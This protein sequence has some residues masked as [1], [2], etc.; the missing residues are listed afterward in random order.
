MHLA[1]LWDDTGAGKPMGGDQKFSHA[2]EAVALGFY[3]QLLFPILTLLTQKRDNAVVGIEQLDDVQ[4]TVGG[5]LLLQQLKHS[6]SSAPKPVTLKSRA[7]WQTV[8]VW[9]DALPH[10]T[11]SEATLHL[12][13]VGGIPDGDP[14]KA[15]YSMDAARDEL[16]NSLLKEA[17]RVVDA[18][19]AAAKA[20]KAAPH[21]DRIEGCQAFL[22]L[23]GTDR[24]NL[25]RRIIIEPNAPPIDQL[26]EKLA[27][28]LTLLPSAKRATV[29][30]RLTEWWARQ[31]IL[32]LC[33][34]RDRVISRIE[35]QDKISRI[36]ADIEEDKILPDFE[37]VSHPEAYQPNGMLTRQIQLVEGSKSD[38]AKAIRE[39]WRAREQRGKWANERLNMKAVMADYDQVLREHWSDRHD[40]MVEECVSADEN[41]KSK[42]GL[43]ILRWSHDDAPSDVRPIVSGWNAA[44]YVRGSYQVLAI[45][46]L[47]G[48]HPHYVARLETKK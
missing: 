20:G 8:K 13:T 36:V 46:L 19:A 21:A 28:H 15:L 11:L 32:S 22:T 2:V 38:L 30:K 45:D 16:A 34:Q 3:Y 17:Q 25:L 41:E 47:V 6:V 14:L 4:L 27:E 40:R 24:L 1:R 26:E 44:Y 31:M 42:A 29:A 7:F 48:W 43:A 39:E 18:R 35:L 9:I 23:S 37:M 5:Q 10:L 33:G 12:V